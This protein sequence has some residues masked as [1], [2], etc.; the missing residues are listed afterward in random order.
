MLRT[1]GLLLLVAGAGLAWLTLVDRASALALTVVEWEGRVGLPLWALALGTG[2]VAVLTSWRPRRS[3]PPPPPP[4]RA[5]VRPAP[6]AGG[7]TWVEEVERRAAALT[8]EPGALLTLDLERPIAF[9]LHLSG[10]P[11][12]R[13]RRAMTTF[14]D[15]LGMV[16]TPERARIHFKDCTPPPVPR[17]KQ[18]MGALRRRYAPDDVN[19][20]GTGDEVE[21]IFAR[22]D[23]RWR[24]LREDKLRG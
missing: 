4:P 3:A 9:E 1:L 11:P 13:A 15:F 8:F 12:E 6:E 7:G 10:M 18:V 23:P 20:V 14:A 21:L 19:V 22:P 16:P 24:I 2:V 5:E 17:A